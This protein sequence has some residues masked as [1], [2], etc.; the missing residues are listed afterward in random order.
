MTQ[1]RET[2]RTVSPFT[3]SFSVQC[4][5]GMEQLKRDENRVDC[6]FIMIPTFEIPVLGEIQTDFEGS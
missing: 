6:V 1:D 2:W 5:V 3:A 4:L